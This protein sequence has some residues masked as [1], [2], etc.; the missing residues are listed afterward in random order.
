MFICVSCDLLSILYLCPIRNRKTEIQR[1]TTAQKIVF[2]H[3]I[4]KRFRYLK[5]T[6]QRDI[7][8]FLLNNTKIAEQFSEYIKI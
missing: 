3:R 2:I 5:P 1:M 7:K 8:E 4:A 6:V